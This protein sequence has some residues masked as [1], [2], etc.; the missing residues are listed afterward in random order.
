MNAGLVKSRA[1][2][3]YVTFGKRGAYGGVVIG[4]PQIP[5]FAK[6]TFEQVQSL[7]ITI[8]LPLA[9]AKGRI[10][11]R[12]PMACIADV[13]ILDGSYLAGAKLG[14]KPI[15]I[16]LFPASGGVTGGTTTTGGAVPA[17]VSVQRG[18]CPTTPLLSRTWAIRFLN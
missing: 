2:P 5:T 18:D 1:G 11:A 15:P 12:S 4:F 3:M 7:V 9:C 6:P 14:R 17:T 13:G 8:S 10:D 16:G